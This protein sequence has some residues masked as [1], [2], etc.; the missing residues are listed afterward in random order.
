M[1]HDEERGADDAVIG[2]IN[3]RLGDRKAL[4]VERGDHAVFAVD[5]V[6]GRQQL[7]RRLAPEHVT[8]RRRLQEVGRVGLAAFEL[9]DRKRAGEALH[10]FAQIGLEPAGIEPQAFGDLLGAGKSALAVGGVHPLLLRLMTVLVRLFAHRSVMTAA[11]TTA[12]GRTIISNAA[13]R[14][15]Y[16]DLAECPYFLAR[17]RG[18]RC[19]ADRSLRA[20]LC[21]K[22]PR[23]RASAPPSRFCPAQRR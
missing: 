2:A 10:V 5:R 15:A 11:A 22:S 16:C 21:G 20:S 7:A 4:R 8:A 18:R 13:A 3:D 19:R 9:A 6:G 17:W 1:R 14:P 23:R 12:I